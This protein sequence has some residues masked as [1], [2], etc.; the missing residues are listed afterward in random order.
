MLLP[1]FLSFS[2]SM[3]IFPV[4]YY[5]VPSPTTMTQETWS[6]LLTWHVLRFSFIFPSH[7]MVLLAG[8][9]THMDTFSTTLPAHLLLPSPPPL[10]AT[11]L[12]ACLLPPAPPVSATAHHSTDCL[13]CL[14]APLPL[15]CLSCCF[16]CMGTTTLLFCLGIV[17]EVKRTG[18]GGRTGH[19]LWHGI[20]LCWV[21]DRTWLAWLE[22]GP[23][24]TCRPPTLK[25]Q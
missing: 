4:F 20:W 21:W 11:M 1:S 17:F 8:M 9:P 14:H 5:I 25:P 23:L 10:P 3:Y 19:F 6:C 12:A 7:G 22:E 16:C 15:S 18:G 13:H 2:L 24:D